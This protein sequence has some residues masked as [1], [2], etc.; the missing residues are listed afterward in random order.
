MTNNSL[1][2][3]LTSV[4]GKVRVK[5]ISLLNDPNEGM[6]GSWSGMDKNTLFTLLRTS[7]NHDV[8]L[9]EVLF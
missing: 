3:S 9:H 7:R 6:L 1:T 5:F 2:M 4:L 8:R